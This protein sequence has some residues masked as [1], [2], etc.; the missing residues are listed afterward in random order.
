MKK[1]LVVLAI[2][3]IT[4]FAVSAVPTTVGSGNL[5]VYGKIGAGTVSF[6][7]TQT[8]TAL[9][10]L[11]TN[12]AMQ[13]TGDG[14]VLGKWDFTGANQGS[15]ILYTV[16]YANTDLV[17]SAGGG[18]SIPFEVIELDGTT[19]VTQT[20]GATTFTAPIG[21]SSETRNIAVRLTGAVPGAA[22]ADENYTGSITI[23]LT[24]G[25]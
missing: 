2:L 21:S 22:P 1:F 14:V 20:G 9:I 6:L 5:N 12:T 17:T 11:K 19:P 10:D 16:T 18:Y 25:S 3:A 8:N 7:V 13:T 4:V 23:T 24:T 15:S